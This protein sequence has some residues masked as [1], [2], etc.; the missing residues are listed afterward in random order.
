MP[1]FDEQGRRGDVPLEDEGGYDELDQTK[2][3]IRTR[4]S[5]Q[6]PMERLYGRGTDPLPYGWTPED[7]AYFQEQIDQHAQLPWDY[8]PRMT[9]GEKDEIRAKVMRWRNNPA[10][11]QLVKQ[12][13]QK[14]KQAIKQRQRQSQADWYNPEAFKGP[15]H[16]PFD[17]RGDYA[18]IGP[19]SQFEAAHA[20]RGGVTIG[21][22]F[23]RGGQFIPG[24]VMAKA[25]PEERAAVEGGETKSKPLPPPTGIVAPRAPKVESTPPREA[26][27]LG[28]PAV[29][30]DVPAPPHDPILKSPGLTP[31]EAK[32][33]EW[34]QHYARQYY[35][36][37][38]DKYLQKNGSFDAAGNLM[39]VS[40][41]TDEWRELIPGY[42]G[43]NAHAV[44]EAS[45]WLNKALSREV[46]NAQRGKG[47]NKFM[48]LAGGGG[49]GKGTATGDFFTLSEY[50]IILDQVSDHFQKLEGKLDEARQAGYEPVFTFVDR[51]PE[52]AA[53]GIV[54]RA[55]NLRK[56]GEVARTVPIERG[57]HA[58]IKSR[59][60]ALDLLRR[61]PDIEPNVIDNRGGRYKR[62]LIKDRDE[63]ISY[64]EQRVAEDKAT[65]ESG[66]GQRIRDSIIQRTLAGEI[67][68]DLTAGF[69]GHD[70]RA[71]V[72]PIP[73][74]ASRA[75]SSTPHRY[76]V[77]HRSG[78]RRPPSL[79]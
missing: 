58:N 52:D 28:P 39:S 48:V 25:S 56:K 2:R 31:D 54:G 11:A 77:P 4:R 46:L 14:I 23:F 17:T 3:M 69:L 20:P 61:R 55:L 7:D 44:H 66:L 16:D 35:P 10:S 41:N 33:E 50:P 38:R 13:G 27:V 40:L 78:V 32:L 19:M 74:H 1:V 26:P 68:E 43:T 18:A 8:W 37:I 75:S 62:R 6:D 45:S 34:S 57:L 53:G 30:L 9:Q 71:S 24:E 79:P 64:L 42:V 67:P 12:W 76:A 29:R 59:E 21:G 60:T 73:T 72:P 51:P 70:W 65:L 22:K 15:E 63:A 5:P 36:Q 47:N 49:S